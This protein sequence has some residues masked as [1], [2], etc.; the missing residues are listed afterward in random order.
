MLERYGES[1]KGVFEKIYNKL[2]DGRYS[3]SEEASN[4]L[5]ISLRKRLGPDDF[6]KVF[7]QALEDYKTNE[8]QHDRDDWNWDTN[9][10]ACKATLY[11]LQAR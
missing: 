10:P 7:K 3:S 2:A 5:V 6:I 1:Q 9:S 4:D 11:P 8:S